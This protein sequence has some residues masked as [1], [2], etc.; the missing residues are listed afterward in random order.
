MRGDILHFTFWKS[1]A[2]KRGL[3]MIS[4][5]YVDDWSPLLHIISRFL[6]EKGDIIVETSLSPEEACRKMDFFSFDVIITDYNSKDSAG[7]GLL[8]QTRQKGKM[9]PFV[10]FTLEQNRVMEQEAAR[11]G[12]VA[13]VRKIQ[14]SD[15]SFYEL[16]KKI[17]T[18]IPAPH[19][20][21]I[22]PKKDPIYPIS[23]EPSS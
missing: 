7:I 19:S 17:R 4:V 1:W 2:L 11:Y 9:T 10:F 21:N 16:E 6:M 18:T 22:I 13:F 20:G 8:Q 12:H 14:N 5:L 15:S 23:G 3:F